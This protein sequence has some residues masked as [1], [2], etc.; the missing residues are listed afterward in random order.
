LQNL[1]AEAVAAL[2]RRKMHREQYCPSCPWVFAN[3]H[4][5]RIANIRKGFESACEK[6]GITDFHPHDLRHT[7]AAWLVQDGVDIRVVCELLRHT[8][9]Q[10]TMRYAH[11]SLDLRVFKV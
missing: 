6:A 5:E 4:G 11:L 2:E 7:C 8:S 3:R 1:N 10:V 9:I